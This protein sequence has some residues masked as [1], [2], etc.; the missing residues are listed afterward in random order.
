MHLKYKLFLY[1]AKIFACIL[2][3]AQNYR[4][5]LHSIRR[6]K[7]LSLYIIMMINV[8]KTFMILPMQH[9]MV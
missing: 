8:K 6:H 7:K 3:D 2:N 4:I 1:G 5:V 9:N